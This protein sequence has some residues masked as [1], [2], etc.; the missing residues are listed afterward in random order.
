LRVSLHYVRTEGLR[1]A[2][3]GALGLLHP[4]RLAKTLRYLREDDRLRSLGAGLLL[5]R[6]LGVRSDRDILAGP[7]GRPFLRA[8]GPHFSLSHSGGLVALSVAPSP[9]GL[10][11][12]DL[13][14]ALRPDR[15]APRIMGPGELAMN[16]GSER[17]P[18]LL[19]PIWTRKE[20]VMKATG[21]GF[22][23]DPR[24]FCVSPPGAGPLRILGAAWHISTMTLHGHVVSLA[25]TDGPLEVLPEEA[26]P[27]DLLPGASG[28]QPGPP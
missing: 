4:A 13:G 14:R 3:P 18:G 6:F 19:L 5:R 9:H 2:L 21:Q 28:P 8:G 17:D 15:V 24:S 26:A 23:L 10:D 7:N 16:P 22:G 1:G 25:A 11:L 12:E 20:S 27:S